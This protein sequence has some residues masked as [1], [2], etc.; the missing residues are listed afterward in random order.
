MVELNIVDT[1]VF[2]ESHKCNDCITLSISK[3]KN[4]Q[5]KAFYDLK[6]SNKKNSSIQKDITIKTSR[7]PKNL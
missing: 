3:G 2:T 7:P 5:L 1:H 6:T 4:A